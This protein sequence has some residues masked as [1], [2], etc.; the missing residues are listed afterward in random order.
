MAY[1]G[2]VWSLDRAV[3]TDQSQQQGL[4]Q[5]PIDDNLGLALQPAKH[6]N[7]HEITSQHVGYNSSLISNAF[8]TDVVQI[9]ACI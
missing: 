5:P 1:M 6:E 3:T 9:G 7:L 8:S 2:F 4:S